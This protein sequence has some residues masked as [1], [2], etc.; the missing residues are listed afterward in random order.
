MPEAVA[1]RE[2]VLGPEVGEGCGKAAVAKMDLRRPDETLGRV[3]MP[4][5]QS[6]HEKEPLERD[7][8]TVDGLAVE[9]EILREGGD[10]EKLGGSPREQLQQPGH[11]AAV[12]DAG[13]VAD[14]ALD[15]GAEILA[16]PLPRPHRAPAVRLGFAA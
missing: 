10:V 8:V 7:E 6:A 3:A 14:V 15:D 11:V 2:P 13:H 9:G 5:R 1:L 16:M 4:R 12:A